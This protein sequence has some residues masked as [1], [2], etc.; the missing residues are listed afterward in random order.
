MQQLLLLADDRSKPQVLRALNT[1]FEKLLT[2]CNEV[3]DARVPREWDP[4]FV[5]DCSWIYA[6]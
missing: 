4:S 6:S 1:H 5:V 2:G 3:R